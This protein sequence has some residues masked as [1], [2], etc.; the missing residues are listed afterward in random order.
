MNYI[1]KVGRMQMMNK[2][3]FI[4]VPLT[5]MAAAVLVVILIG[6]VF[7]PGDQLFY[8][9]A[10]Q[11]PLWYFLGAGIQALTLAFPFSQGMSI[12]RRN[13]YLGTMATFAIVSLAFAVLFFL[14]GL[15]EKATRGWFVGGMVFALPWVS[16]GPWFGTV[17]MVWMVAFL[18]FSIGFWA[19]TIF[20]RWGVTGLLVSGLGTASVLLVIAA[21]FT[22]SHRWGAFAHFAIQQTPIT[23]AIGIAVVILLLAAGSYLTLRRATP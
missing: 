18:L 12:T 10:G 19:A 4:G 2:W 6:A 14:L 5:I 8:T 3:V 16:S 9:G 23:V 22:M 11:A 17:A 15:V 20:K 13:Y 7:V 21:I 1:V